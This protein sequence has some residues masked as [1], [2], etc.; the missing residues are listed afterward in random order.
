MLIYHK[1]CMDGFCCAWLM[2]KYRGEKEFVA[3]QYGDEPPEVTGKHVVI[4]DFSFSREIMEKIATS[5]ASLVCLDHHKTAEEKLRGLSYCIFDMTKSGGELVESW[6]GVD[7]GW[8]VRYTADRDLWKW[9]LFKSKEISAAIRSYPTTFEAWE[10]LDRRNTADIIREGEAILRYQQQIITE[11]TLRAWVMEVGGY[12][13]WGVEATTLHS[14]IAGELARKGTFGVCWKEVEGGRVMSL[15]SEGD[16]DVSE[17]AR[18]YGGGGHKN[19]ANFIVKGE[20]C[21]AKVD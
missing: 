12:K 2:W 14:E 17:V 8:L 13:V 9:K 1:N 4:A 11:H 20:F 5:A 15:R 10:I 19:A 18:V 6:L 3:C 7:G 16:F 21:V